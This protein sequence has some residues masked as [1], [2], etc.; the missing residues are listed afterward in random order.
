MARK[1]EHVHEDHVDESWLIPYA[2]LLTLLLA[3]FIVLYAASNVDKVKYN[4]IAAAFNEVMGPSGIVGFIHGIEEGGFTL[5]FPDAGL[6]EGGGEGGNEDRDIEDLQLVLMD[7]LEEAGLEGQVVTSIDERG[8]IVS[9]SDAVLFDSGSAEIKPEYRE[10]L[11]GV[12]EAMNRLHNFI[13]VEGHTDN[14]PMNSAMFPTNWELSVGRA[15][16]VVRL[17]IEEANVPSYKLS[18]VGYGAYRPVADNDTVEG[19]AE[20]RRVDIIILS[21]R[22]NVLEQQHPH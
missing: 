14:V 9:M 7:L 3:L 4:E 17:F 22:Y 19:R 16:R 15:A 21:S 20:N 1:R 8:L 11:I 5:P 13:R 12:G 2:D 10:V 18:A 6:E